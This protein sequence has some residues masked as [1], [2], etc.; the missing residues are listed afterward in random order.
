MYGLRT[1]P[2]L[3]NIAKILATQP[4]GTSLEPCEMYVEGKKIATE[5]II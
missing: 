3:T 2:V 4:D 5:H 1:I